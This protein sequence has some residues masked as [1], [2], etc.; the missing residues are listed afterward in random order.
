MSTHRILVVNPGSTSTKLGLFEDEKQVAAQKIEHPAF[1]LEKFPRTM[2]QYGLRRQ[3]M[4]EFLKERQILPRQLSAVVARG[5]LLKPLPSGTY[6][7][8]AKIVEDLAASRYGEHASNIAAILA[9]G[10]QWDFQIPAFLVD[11]VVVDELSDIAR[12]SGLK[13]I[14]RRSLWHALNILAV[15]R[16]VCRREN[17]NFRDENFVIA[18]LGGGISVAAIDHGRCIDVSNGLEAGPYSPERAGT[19]PSLELVDLCFSGKHTHAEM[20]R[21]IVGNGG[22]V[23]YLGTSNLVE[24]EHRI[25]QGDDYAQLVLAGMCY[26]ISKEIG[27]FVA[28][29]KGKVKRI[30]LTGGAANSTLIVS[31]IKEHTE[32]FAPVVVVP[33]EDELSALALGCLRVL[34]KEENARSYSDV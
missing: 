6:R 18:H 34:R 31:R 12:L 32:A 13:E 33:G 1:E 27:S 30:I 3:V 14:P 8:C 26:Q 11:P 28:V 25:G 7:I 23:N 29:L 4:L 5:G 21:L 2:D 16:L 22:L 17:W 10:L 15:T 9:Y 24:I 19:L 20:R